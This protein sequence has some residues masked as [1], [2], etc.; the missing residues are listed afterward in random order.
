MPSEKILEQKK[1]IVAELTEKVANAKMGVVVDYKGITVEDDTKLRK[2]LREADVEYKVVK[3]TYLR[4]AFGSNNLE[5]LNSQL[6][7]TTAIAMWSNDS[8]E[9]AKLL[10][11]QAEALKTF[12]IKG[13]FMDGKAIDADTVNDLAKLP[14][15]EVLIA[16]VLGGLNAPVAAFARVLNAIVEKESA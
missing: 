14:P 10:A 1:V 15:R 13:G 16:Q 6:E 9:G 12:N 3:N 2:A 4:F 8:F 11:K 7:G 5:E